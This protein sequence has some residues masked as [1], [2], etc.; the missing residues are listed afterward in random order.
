MF[1]CVCVCACMCLLYIERGSCLRGSLRAV[2]QGTVAV[3]LESSQADPA[4]SAW[5]SVP[6]SLCFPHSGS[7]FFSLLFFSWLSLSSESFFIYFFVL[8]SFCGSVFLFLCYVTLPLSLLILLLSL[9]LQEE[10][11][12]GGAPQSGNTPIIAFWSL[13]HDEVRQGK[14][15]H[16]NTHTQK[17]THTQKDTR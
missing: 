6:P 8:L 17:L 9:S 7:L 14:S 2:Q 3:T 5:H 11:S 10:G 13:W 15:T 4:M 16:T 1:V 12:V